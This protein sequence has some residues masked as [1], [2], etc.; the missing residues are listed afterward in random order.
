MT[1]E[2]K[3][4]VSAFC[5]CGGLFRGEGL[6]SE[7]NAVAMMAAFWTAHTGLGHGTTSE[8]AADWAARRRVAAYS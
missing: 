4:D 6:T 3:M 8:E 7:E 2:P 5:V 1:T